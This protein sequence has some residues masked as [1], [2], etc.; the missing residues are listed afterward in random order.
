MSNDVKINLFGVD[1]LN[2]FF[3]RLA[4]SDQ[5]RVFLDAFRIGSKPLIKTSRQNLKAR[6]DKKGSGELSRSMGF[7]NTTRGRHTNF[8]SAKVGARRGG[9]F[10]G[11]HGHLKD[12]GTAE[13][14]T[15]QGFSRGSARASRFF[16][17]AKTATEP[18]LITETQ[19]NVLTA[20]DKLINKTLPKRL[21]K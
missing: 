14:T 3:E 1:E 12:A 9:R 16:T 7:V 21:N 4:K 18:Q 17:D 20:L 19:N 11:Y 6:T 13:R 5:R 10:R 15:R 2:R 8:I